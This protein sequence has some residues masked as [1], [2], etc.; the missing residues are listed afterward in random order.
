MT[1]S[2]QN[3]F[4]SSAKPENTGEQVIPPMK[5]AND[6][7]DFVELVTFTVV[8]I[9]LLS[10]FF[11]RH[12]I[13][14]GGSMDQTLEDGEHLIISDFFYSPK[15]GDIVVFEAL[16]GNFETPLVKR[17]IAV[18][19]QSVAMQDGVVYI[20]GI[21]LDED[22][23]YLDFSD[24]KD[25]FTELTVPDGYVFVM[26]DHRNNSRDSRDSAVGLVD[27]RSILGHVILRVTPFNRF[28]RVN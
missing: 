3:L 19:G 12:S 1:D 8:A 28:G 26:G 9:L 4:P 14:Q 7:F 2:E 27:I 16:N 25:S 20:D 23:T 11:I 6:L 15:N 10:T 5:R 22:Y 17:V 13:V 21:A 18:P 24:P